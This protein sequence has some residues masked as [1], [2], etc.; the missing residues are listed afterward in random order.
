MKNL[1]IISLVL[2]LLVKFQVF[3]QFELTNQAKLIVEGEVKSTLSKWNEDKTQIVTESLV[4]IKS[5]FKG[6]LRDS[7]INIETIGG[8]VE[9]NYH[10]RPHA[11][12]LNKGDQGYFFLN[13]SYEFISNSGGFAYIIQDLNKKVRFRGEIINQ[14]FFEN[15]IIKVTKFP[16][17][18]THKYFALFKAKRFRNSDTC[19]IISSLRT[20][21][22]IDF[23]FKNVKYTNNLQYLEFDINAKVNT[24]GLKFGKGNLYI[25]YTSHFG[26]NVISKNT[27]EVTKGTILQNSIYNLTTTDYGAQLIKISIQPSYGSNSLYTFSETDEQLVHIKV[28][29]SDFTSMGSIS[30]DDIDISGEVYYWCKGSYGL[31]NETNLSDP[32]SAT[33]G[34]Q[35]NTTGLIYTF[36]NVTYSAS[37]NKLSVDL[38]AQATQTSRYSDGI[39]YINYNDLGF[40]SNVVSNNTLTFQKQDLLDNTNYSFTTSDIDQNT[41]SLIIFNLS[42]NSNDYNMLGTTPRKLGKLTFNVLN[43]SEQKNINFDQITESSDHTHFNGY[44]PLAWELYSPVIADDQE[45]G[46][47]CD[48]KKPTITSFSPSIIHGGVGEELTIIGKNFGTFVPQV[49]TILFKN[50]DYSGPSDIEVGTSDFRWD[51]ILHWTDTEIKIKIPGCDKNKGT[52]QPPATGKFRVKNFCDVSDESSNKLDIPYSIINYRGAPHSQANRIGLQPNTICF[53]FSNQVPFWVKQQFEIALSDWCSQT[54]ISFKLGPTIIKNTPFV[55]ADGTSLVSFE[56]GSGGGMFVVSDYF[57]SNK[58]FSEIDF[59]LRTTLTSPTTADEE[60]M[61]ELIKHELGHAHMLN[62]AKGLGQLMHPSGNTGGFITSNDKN[63]ANLVFGASS[64][65]SGIG[66]GGCGG[67]CTSSIHDNHV[68]NFHI[69]PNPVTNIL[70]IKSSEEKDF[71]VEI[72]NNQGIILKSFDNLKT[73]NDLNISDLPAGIYICRI[74]NILVVSNKKFVK[75]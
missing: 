7:I 3:S 73:E 47:I 50:G 40:G 11:I 49:S 27:I 14:N 72:I 16:K 24:P 6:E 30:F 4:K 31:F 29:I 61:R 21:K 33:N 53:S 12:K 37:T 52:S 59:V 38:F 55:A 54:G 34:T 57:G 48:C 32:I 19:E 9:G 68:V 26:T 44:F 45:T 20:N 67:T 25:T 42:T 36:E 41:F 43:C 71:H 60:N 62:H 23:S 69:S 22:T 65:C 63:G 10:Y 2:F 35:G 18:S 17:I 75:I 66:M 15:E 39:I 56:S 5:V 58:C 46:T 70:Y 51:N 28:K 74:T 8:E 1:K 13:N 64:V